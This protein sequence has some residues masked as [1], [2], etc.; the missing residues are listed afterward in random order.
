MQ[1]ATNYVRGDEPVLKSRNVIG[2]ACRRGEE[3]LVQEFFE[4]FKTP[5]EFYSPGSVYSAVVSTDVEL[6]DVHSKLL[7]VYSSDGAG[8]TSENASIDYGDVALP[9]YGKLRS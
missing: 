8:H 3:P 7:V 9:I 4:L 2:V 6:R 1:P 5:W